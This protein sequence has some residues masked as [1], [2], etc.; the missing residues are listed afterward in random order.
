MATID[1]RPSTNLLD[2][3]AL[4]ELVESVSPVAAA[5]ALAHELGGHIGATDVR[6]WIADYSGRAVVA[7]DSGADGSRT[8]RSAGRRR[9]DNGGY[10][11]ALRS[12]RVQVLGADSAVRLLAPVTNRGDSIGVLEML[13]PAEPDRATLDYVQAAAR[14]L[15]YVVAGN[16]QFT[17]LYE[18]GMRTTNFTL[19]AEIQR[20]LLPAAFSC[21]TGVATV[22]AWMEPAHSVGGDTFDYSVDV[23]NL[24]LSVTD[25]MG[26]DLP[27]A[28]LATLLVGA[29]RNGRR[30]GLDLAAQADRAGAAVR[31]NSEFGQF[32]T[33]QVVRVDL[34]SGAAEIV[35]AGHPPP[36]RLRQSKLEAVELDVDLPFGLADS[37][38][39][40]QRF[41]LEPGDRVI[42]VT[43]GMFE[44]EA[45]EAD[46]D[47]AIMDTA[48]EHAREAVH[49]LTAAVVEVTGGDHRDDATVM[50][51]DWHGA[52]ARSGGSR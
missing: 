27:G 50:C 39:Q 23:S 1:D 44:R 52:D 16:R 20:R 46:L 12:Q 19:A 33:G 30:T 51:L 28:M 45:A 29:L 7:T 10:S 42:F 18:W 34:D 31:D 5:D 9:L 21:E 8:V 32:V 37:P 49:A 48:G 13:L 36:L 15:A 41:D 25:A 3:R 38:Y 40:V 11:E 6:F 17:D 43:D 22:A 26:H 2:L 4:L 14:A 24:H 35:N 47:G